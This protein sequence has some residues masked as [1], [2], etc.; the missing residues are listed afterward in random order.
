MGTFILL[1]GMLVAGTQPIPYNLAH[2]GTST[3]TSIPDL[4]NAESSPLTGAGFPVQHFKMW[5]TAYTSSP[6]ETDD[7][8]HVTAMGSKTRDGI[9]ATNMLPFGTRVKF[10]SLFG[11]KIFVVEDRMH[12]RKKNFIDIWMPEKKEALRFGIAY[13]DVLVLR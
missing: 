6:E 8:P 2:G 5:V 9:V 3:I 1:A 13:A 10:P 12:P 4:G 7:T 11:E